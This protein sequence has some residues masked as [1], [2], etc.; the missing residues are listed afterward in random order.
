MNNLI[1]M[2]TLHLLFSHTLTPDQQAD[3]KDKLQIADFRVLPADLQQHFSHVP[4]D[5]LD[6]DEYAQP[7][8]D[9]LKQNAQTGDFALV[10]GDFGLAFMLANYC[11]EIGV[12][13]VY[14]T[15][16]RQSVEVVQEDGSVVTQRVFRHRLFRKY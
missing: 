6:L 9:W 4:A 10:Q 11:K 2:K 12:I 15:T 5:L 16:E 8:K 13:P 7:L 1:N 3:A 14:S